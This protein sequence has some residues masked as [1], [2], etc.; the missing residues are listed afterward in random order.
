[1][2]SSRKRKKPSAERAVYTPRALREL[3]A[4]S[5]WIARDNPAASR[6][7]R[8][9][10]DQAARRIAHFPEFGR[11]RPNVVRPPLRVLALTGFPYVIVSDGTPVPP[12]IVS[13]VHGARDLTDALADL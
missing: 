8:H 10:V 11:L 12:R 9:A 7:L 13:V 6:A 3:A 4:A 2:R 5:R 1:M